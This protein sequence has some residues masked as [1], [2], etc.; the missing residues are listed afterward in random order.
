MTANTAWEEG[1]AAGVMR[2]HRKSPPMTVEQIQVTLVAFLEECLCPDA[3]LLASAGE[4]DMRRRLIPIRL[5]AMGVA[6]GHP[7]IEIRWRGQSY[8]LE[9]MGI[10]GLL[11][12]AQT[13]MLRRLAATGAEVGV[14]YGL[15]AAMRQ[16][17]R[18]GLLKIEGTP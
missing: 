2:R 5:K 4:T 8:F 11:N 17:A 9:L 13:A 15:D 1:E 10:D 7:R 3:V 6:A 12:N 14:A 18:W 16:V